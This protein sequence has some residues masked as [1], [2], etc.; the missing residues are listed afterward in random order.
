MFRHK[1]G[2]QTSDQ[3]DKAVSREVGVLLVLASALP[4]GWGAGSEAA[5]LQQGSCA[6]GALRAQGSESLLPSRAA[7]GPPS[8]TVPE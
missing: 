2:W 5:T 3:Q 8:P 6:A 4:E 1:L 7:P